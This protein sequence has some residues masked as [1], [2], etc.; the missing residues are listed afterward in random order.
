MS[1]VSTNPPTQTES[2]SGK[3]K[4]KA[5]AGKSEKALSVTSATPSAGEEPN[6]GHTTGAESSAT[7]AA[8]DGP[9]GTGSK[10]YESP[11]IR[12]LYK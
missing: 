3:K 7:A 12:E 9:N 1:A 5:K 2:N 4:N 10:D 8:A 6:P 11:Y